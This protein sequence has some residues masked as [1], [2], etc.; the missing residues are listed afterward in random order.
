MGAIYEFTK[1]DSP[2]EVL[3]Q[4]P[5]EIVGNTLS[6]YKY[7]IDLPF[8]NDISDDLFT[9]LCSRF[10]FKFGKEPSHFEIKH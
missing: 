8:L 4:N 3:S 1:I 6:E 2:A 9:M 5:L 10:R 7:E